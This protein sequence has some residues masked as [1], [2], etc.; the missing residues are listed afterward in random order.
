MKWRSIKV[1]RGR[2]KGHTKYECGFVMHINIVF[3]YVDAVPLNKM[4]SASNSSWNKDWPDLAG[5][6]FIA[7][8]SR[9]VAVV[10]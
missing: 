10:P 9:H 4:S 3:S 7:S 1:R 8:P 5:F 6:I 2:E